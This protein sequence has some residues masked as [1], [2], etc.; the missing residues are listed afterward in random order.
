MHDMHNLQSLQLCEQSPVGLHFEKKLYNY[1]E[2]NN[3]V[4]YEGFVFFNIAQNLLDQKSLKV[5]STEENSI[6]LHAITKMR[7]VADC[8][9]KASYA[10]QL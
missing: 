3:F 4:A 5:G 9:K 2:I 8:L 1:F 10:S 7:Y 6:I